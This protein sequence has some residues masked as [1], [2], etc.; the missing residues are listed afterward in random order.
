MRRQKRNPDNIQLNFVESLPKRG[1]SLQIRRVSYPLDK[2]S[3]E[4]ASTGGSGVSS[5]SS[6]PDDDTD[7]F[8]CALPHGCDGLG[9]D[10][11]PLESSTGRT[12][13]YGESHTERKEKAA[14]AWAEL[15]PNLVPAVISASGFPLDVMCAFCKSSSA[16]IWCKDCGASAY[17]C[18]ECTQKLHGDINL[19]HSP[20]LWKVIIDH[21]PPLSLTHTIPFM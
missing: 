11:V 17:L 1:R 20:L 9:S 2:L 10:P 12:S 21:S 18:E 8:G 4:P 6:I 16:N 3:I 5:A 14:R 15:R 13:N 7:A 19:F